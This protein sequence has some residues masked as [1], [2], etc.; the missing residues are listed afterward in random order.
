MLKSITFNFVKCC[1]CHS[2]TYKQNKTKQNKT[3]QNKTK[4]NT[5]QNKTKQNKKK[6]KNKNKTKQNTHIH[7]KLAWFLFIRYMNKFGESHI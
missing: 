3:K 5:K 7:T 4:Q 6:N 2:L 1:L